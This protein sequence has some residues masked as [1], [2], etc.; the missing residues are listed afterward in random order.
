V[1]RE[2]GADHGDMGANLIEAR[3]VDDGDIITAS[4]VTASIDL[5]LWLV[6]NTAVQTRRLRLP[7]N[8][9]LNCVG[10]YGNGRKARI[11]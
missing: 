8:W 7:E 11:P 9:I 6:Q 10:R 2:N 5:G 4:G 1:V 3:V